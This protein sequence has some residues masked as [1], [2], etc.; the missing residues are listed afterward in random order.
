MKFE[1]ENHKIEVKSLWLNIK[2]FDWKWLTHQFPRRNPRNK[3]TLLN[4]KHQKWRKWVNSQLRHCSCI[5][6]G[7]IITIVRPC[8]QSRRMGRNNIIIARP[9]FIIMK[10][11]SKALDIRFGKLAKSLIGPLRFVQNSE[12]ANHLCYPTKFDV[13]GSMEPYKIE[14]GVFLTPNLIKCN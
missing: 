12:H 6:K 8:L 7:T 2:D 10:S 5:K 13:P 14:S 11:K 3:I 4:S 1:N 9:L